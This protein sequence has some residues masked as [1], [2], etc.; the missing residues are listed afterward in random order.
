M[1]FKE[2][3]NRILSVTVKVLNNYD[4]YKL[5]DMDK[6]D[7]NMKYAA[8]AWK[9]TEGA[10]LR[11]FNEQAQIDSVNGALALRP[12]IE[13]IIDQIW[14]EGFDGIYFIGIGGTYASSM[15]VEVYMRGRSK[16]PIYVENA[17]EFL[18]TGNKRFTEKS[19]VIYSSVSGNTKE[20]VQ[21]VDRVHEI[22]ARVFAFIDTPDSILTQP[23]KQ[24]YLILYPMNEQL[25][26]YMT[27]NYLMYKNGEFDEY[28]RYNK[29]METY[30]AEIGRAHV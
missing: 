4:N 25:K 17:A 28:D 24:D 8:K 26:F 5:K 2:K 27:A 6:G 18:T 29:E 10:S 20:M 7:K 30:L 13:T 16:L 22:G 3:Q 12:Q 15:Q 23:D 11:N 1:I 9:E 14:E 19:V 21:L